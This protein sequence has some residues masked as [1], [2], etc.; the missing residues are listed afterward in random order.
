[1]V[2]LIREL[3]YLALGSGHKR[4]KDQGAGPRTGAANFRRSNAGQRSDQQFNEHMRTW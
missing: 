3:L 1:V 2:K 4:Q